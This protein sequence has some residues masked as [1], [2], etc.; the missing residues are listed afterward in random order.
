MSPKW[1]STFGT[2]LTWPGRE[3][4][5]ASASRESAVVLVNLGFSVDPSR[6]S[7]GISFSIEP[8]FLPKAD[9]QYGT[10]IF[11]WRERMDGI[12]KDEGEGEG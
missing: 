10:P 8:R 3:I 9:G 6:N 11:Q 12:K 7:Y 2:S 1:I 4:G 5:R